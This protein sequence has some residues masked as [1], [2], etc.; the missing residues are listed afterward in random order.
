VWWARRVEFPGDMPRV[1]WY[2]EPGGDDPRAVRPEPQGEPSRAAALQPLCTAAIDIAPQLSA[3]RLLTRAAAG[4]VC[5]P[6]PRAATPEVYERRLTELRAALAARP[7]RC[8]LLVAHWG[9]LR[10]L[11]GRELEPAQLGS[12]ELDL[13]APPAPAG[14]GA[15]RGARGGR[16]LGV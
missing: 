13:A 10:A 2:T 7:E 3:A 12:V 6:H 14:R 5:P 16:A 4:A 15:R 1:W 9:V 11:G 8:V